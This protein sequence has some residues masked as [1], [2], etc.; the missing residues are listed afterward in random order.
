MCVLKLYACVSSS[1][2]RYYVF[3]K[4]RC[5]QAGI[6]AFSTYQSLRMM[7]RQGSF[8]NE[9]RFASPATAHVTL[10]PLSFPPARVNSILKI[11]MVFISRPTER[12]HLI[13]ISA[14]FHSTTIESR[15][16]IAPST[17]YSFSYRSWEGNTW[18]KF[19]PFRRTNEQ[20]RGWC[21]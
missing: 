11:P 16:N 2:R 18:Y 17:R 4:Y 6:P 8:L 20:T 7:T 14:G 19:R 1:F 3:T 5:R 15:L 21:E 13:R 10:T 9:S 12:A